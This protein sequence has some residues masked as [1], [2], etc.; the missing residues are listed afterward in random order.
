MSTRTDLRP[1]TT[2]QITHPIR[3]S[4][5]LSPAAARAIDRRCASRFGISTL[6]LMEN[7]A[8]HVAAAAMELAPPGIMPKV[9]LIAGTGNN[10]GDALASARHL[11]NAGATVSILLVGDPKKLSHDAAV[12]WKTCRRM[13][14][15]ITTAKSS[16]TK[17]LPSALRRLPSEWPDIVIDGL[18]GTGLSRTVE[19]VALEAILVING[20]R[21]KGARVLAIDIPSG[22]DASNGKPLGG[23]VRADVTVTF[24]GLKTGMLAPWADAYLGQVAIADIGVPRSLIESLGKRMASKAETPRSSRI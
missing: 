8:V 18:F 1:A 2:R 21:A 5:V 7:A 24:V 3:P 12:Q 20:L 6:V 11:S 10:G 4:Y 9:L 22:L 19:G 14:L 15:P 16:L 23:A 13:R 17:A